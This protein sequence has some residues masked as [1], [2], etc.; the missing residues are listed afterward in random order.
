MAISSCRGASNN[1]GCPVEPSESI[2]S[3]PRVSTLFVGPVQRPEL[4]LEAVDIAS[5]AGG[6]SE[7]LP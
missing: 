6:G 2:Y 4:A 5:R 3:S 7:Q 1:S